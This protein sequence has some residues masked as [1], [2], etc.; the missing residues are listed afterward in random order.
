MSKGS[1]ILS[2]SVIEFKGKIANHMSTRFSSG[3]SIPTIRSINACAVLARYVAEQGIDLQF[4]LSGTGI[5]ASDLE[6]ENFFTSPEQEIS[7]I[8]N[9]VR[10]IPTPGLGLIIGRRS[11][12]GVFGIIGAAALNSNTFLDAMKIFREFALPYMS[13]FQFDVRIKDSL[14]YTTMKELIDFKEIRLFACER[15]FA[16]LVRIAGDLLG[17]PIRLKELRVA[18]PKPDH[19]SN[20][21]DFFQWPRH[22]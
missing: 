7:V 2:F 14:I 3:K 16:S 22:I 11:H 13:C 12:I 4:L 21:R 8:R 18:Y 19:A 17:A 10:L 5:D 20:Y 15:L 6:D 9:L 1:I